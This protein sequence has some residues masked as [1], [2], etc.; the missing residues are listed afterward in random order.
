MHHRQ[1]QRWA[2][3][4]SMHMCLVASAMLS[5]ALAA[6]VKRRTPPAV[7]QSRA[8]PPWVLPALRVA[9]RMIPSAARGLSLTDLCGPGYRELGPS[10]THHACVR[11]GVVTGRAPAGTKHAKG[12]WVGAWGPLCPTRSDRLFTPA[13]SLP[14]HPRLPHRVRPWDRR[15][16]L[17]SAH[18]V[19]G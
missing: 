17:V 14:R 4:R 6:P 16:E 15:P 3:C 11:A 10:F 2:L 5:L 8:R 9:Q 1:A 7:R 18:S 13:P 12:G 19:S